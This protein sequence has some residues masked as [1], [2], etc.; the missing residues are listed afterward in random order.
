MVFVEVKPTFSEQV[1]VA[2]HGAFGGVE[3]GSELVNGFMGGFLQV[4]NELQHAQDLVLV[5]HGVG[6]GQ[7]TKK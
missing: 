4:A 2:I 7:R 6:F 1:E 3:K 5:E